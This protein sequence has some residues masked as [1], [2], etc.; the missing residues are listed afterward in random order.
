MCIRPNRLH[1]FRITT[2]D[3]LHNTKHGCEVFLLFF[4][5]VKEE[6]FGVFFLP[7]LKHNL[8]FK[9]LEKSI[10]TYTMREQRGA[11]TGNISS[12][13]KADFSKYRNFN[14]PKF[15]AF[16]VTHFFSV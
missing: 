9:N 7:K 6:T 12:Y 11:Y 16:T 4:A 8:K 13:W 5:A 15:S 14:T 2:I 3:Q 10:I 1:H